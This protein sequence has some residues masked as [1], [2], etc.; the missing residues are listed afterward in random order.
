[1]GCLLSGAHL[2][3]A[4]FVS[5]GAFLLGWLATF[6]VLS[7]VSQAAW[8]YE[9][10]AAFGGAFTV[11]VVLLAWWVGAAMVGV[12]VAGRAIADTQNGRFDRASERLRWMLDKEPFLRLAGFGGGTFARLQL[13]EAY[14]YALHGLSDEA[15]R[16]ALALRGPLNPAAA[17]ATVIAAI[18]A[19]ESGDR[20]A[21]AVL[22]KE[23]D[24]AEKDPRGAT[25]IGVLAGRGHA[26]VLALELAQ[27][28]RVLAVLDAG[29][30]GCRPGHTLRGMIAMLRGAWDAADA[31][32]V[33]ALAVHPSGGKAKGPPPRFLQEP[34]EALRAENARERGDAPRA[35]TLLDAMVAAAQP[36]H[37]EGRVA[38]AEAR[39]EQAAAAGNEAG[40][41][42][43]LAELDAIAG[44]WS[45]SPGTLASVALARARIEAARGRHDAAR[46]AL[47]PALSFVHPI[48]RQRALFAAGESARAL[49]DPAA[50]TFHEQALALSAETHIGRLAAAALS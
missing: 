4:G 39:G 44:H 2:V 1:M 40:A 46:A 9:G 15:L 36:V 37:R 38:V 42:A 14:A 26:H 22:A 5:T 30:P 13:A 41:S 29:A 35:L 25:A 34:L 23:L 18:A 19:A 12:S 11:V 33:A 50:R 20:E 27:A 17:G 3:L 8:R 10:V 45:F 7:T 21:W 6:L 24:A 31:A 48:V 49:G 16:M 28:E 47:G 32:F 43:A